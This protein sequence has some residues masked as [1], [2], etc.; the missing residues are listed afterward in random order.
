[1]NLYT[2]AFYFPHILVL[3]IQQMISSSTYQMADAA[4]GVGMRIT[5]SF[6]Q[7]AHKH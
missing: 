6:L 4:L 5:A 3:F 2:Q 7:L 1:M